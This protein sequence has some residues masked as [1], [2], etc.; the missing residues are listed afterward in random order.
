M[1]DSANIKM[2]SKNSEVKYIH[3]ISQTLKTTIMIN[4]RRK[5]LLV[6]FVLLL[7]SCAGVDFSD[8]AYKQ[9][10]TLK[11]ASLELMSQANESYTLHESDVN[12][13]TSDLNKS[14]AYEKKRKNNEESIRMYMLLINPNGNLL[15]GFL[16]N[17]K[18]SGTLSPT[19]INQFKPQVSEAFDKIIELEDSKR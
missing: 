17:W 13:L 11:T 19:F 2:D 9:D 12:N 18:T 14:L 10:Q 1:Q 16:K 6:L 7:S 3:S 5:L 4:L 15:G 8:Y